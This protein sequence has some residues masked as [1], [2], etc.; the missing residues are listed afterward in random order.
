MDTNLRMLGEH[1]MGSGVL[2]GVRESPRGEVLG[3]NL[4]GGAQRPCAHRSRHLV[5]C[6]GVEG[7]RQDADAKHCLGW[8]QGMVTRQCGIHDFVIP[9]WV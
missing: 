8:P 6:V 3:V 7:S 2:A 9:I 4:K 1:G 5:G